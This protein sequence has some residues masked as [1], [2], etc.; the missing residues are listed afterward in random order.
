MTTATPCY[1]VDEVTGAICS[2]PCNHPHGI[3]GA[4]HR[5]KWDE[6]LEIAWPV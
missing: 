1:E 2:L 5:D 3:G 4:K 6:G